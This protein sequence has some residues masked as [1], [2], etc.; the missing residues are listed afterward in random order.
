LCFIVRIREDEAVWDSSNE[1]A[2]EGPPFVGN[3]KVGVINTV[4]TGYAVGV[5]FRAEGKLLPW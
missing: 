5:N 2:N 3:E 4:E 1:F